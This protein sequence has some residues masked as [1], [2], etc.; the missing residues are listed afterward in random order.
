[1]SALDKETEYFDR[2]RMLLTKFVLKLCEYPGPYIDYASR[3]TSG[4][5]E[6]KR[7]ASIEKVDSDHAQ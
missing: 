7:M 6:V 3:P 5:F 2:L 1:M 4:N